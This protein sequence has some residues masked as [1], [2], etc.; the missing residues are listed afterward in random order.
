MHQ[1]I[2]S[3]ALRMPLIA[4]AV[5][6]RGQLTRATPS[7]FRRASGM[8][9]VVGRLR[10]PNPMLMLTGVSGTASTTR[11]MSSSLRTASG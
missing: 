2:C 9:G 10:T 5:S 4:A 7:A 6:M 8:S 3:R 1:R 11:L